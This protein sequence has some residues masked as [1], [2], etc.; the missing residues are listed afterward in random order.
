MGERK[1]FLLRMDSKLWDEINSWAQQDMRSVNAQ[2]EFLLKEAV[3]RRK[4]GGKQENKE[5]E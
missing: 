4:G 1:P 5:Q 3:R 2:I